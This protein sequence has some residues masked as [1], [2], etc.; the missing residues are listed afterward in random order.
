ML[1]AHALRSR[2]FTIKQIAKHTNHA[3]ST[4]H[5]WLRDF[6]LEREHI[7][8]AI[9][10]DQLLVLL[11]SQAGLLQLNELHPP[12]NRE[13]ADSR[14]RQLQSLAALVRELRL[15][16]GVLLRSRNDHV[17]QWEAPQDLEL[18]AEEVDAVAPLAQLQD[19]LANLLEPPPSDSE[20]TESTA[21]E[22]NSSRP[23]E[24]NLEISER[25]GTPS[26]AHN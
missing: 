10:Q 13:Q 4:V 11:D 12:Q 5:A 16:C 23:I 25:V 1:Q 7:V 6:E 17:F 24:P 15:V 19:L 3:P 18:P 20:P 22:A 2:G 8:A 26:P 14:N 21:T 9:A